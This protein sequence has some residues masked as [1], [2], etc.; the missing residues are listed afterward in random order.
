MTVL[1][2][3]EIPQLLPALK[4][5]GNPGKKSIIQLLAWSRDPHYFA[6]VVPYVT[7]DDES[8]KS[9]A[10]EALASVSSPVD[11][12]KLIDLL[13]NTNNPSYVADL[14]VALAGA[15][16]QITEP[17]LRSAAILK[18]MDTF[19]QKEKLIPVLAM[20]GGREA[21]KTV[22]GEFENG[23][24]EMRSTCFKALTSWKDYSAS[25][26]LYEICA[27]GNKT[28]EAPAFEGYVR[29]V[30]SAPVTDDQRLLLY[31][32]IM[33]YALDADRKNQIITELGK[34][35]TYPSLFIT[36]T[37]LDDPAT[38]AVAARAVMYIALPNAE[39][40]T[41]MYGT[42]VRDALT[43]TVTKLKGSESDYD[44]ELVNKYLGS[45]PEDEGFVPMFNGRDLTGWQ[46]LV[47]NP[48]ARS[49]MKPAELAKKQN[50]ANKRMTDNWSVKDG[51]IYF[52]GKGDNL[53]SIK[54]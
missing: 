27:S 4:D 9:A 35:R 26:A 52:T 10:F 2:S 54:E 30:K 5:A 50:E 36:S 29:Q 40:K 47:E 48:I 13:G 23:S 46:G 7:Y 3:K 1:N 14:Q 31:R 43:K 39:S 25:S 6:T 45:M 22:L 12:D 24:V 51:C 18:A 20:T 44:K 17:E 28:Y 11:Q 21:L 16:N 41:G 8:V 34:I 19:K 49:K 38:S 42:I 32:K 33:P 15:A 53:C 37:F